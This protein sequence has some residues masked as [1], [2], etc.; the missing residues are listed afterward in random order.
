[1]VMAMPWKPHV[2]AWLA[3]LDACRIHGNVEMAECVARQIVGM[4][5]DN[6]ADYGLVSN[7][8]AAAANRHLCVRMLNVRE[9]KKVG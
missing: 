3:L 2:A 4:E 5:P 6:A 8:Y 7:I 9:R 1:M